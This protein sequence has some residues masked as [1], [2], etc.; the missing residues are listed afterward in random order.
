MA[1]QN[2]Y[3]TVG[4]TR[5]YGCVCVYA[6]F[7]FFVCFINHETKFNRQITNADK[8]SGDSLVILEMY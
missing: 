5:F 6:S 4:F 2:T 1:E 3:E 8:K 7:F